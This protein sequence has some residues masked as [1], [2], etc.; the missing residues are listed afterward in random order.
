MVF[1]KF[2][3]LIFK[4]LLLQIN[5][6][7]RLEFFFFLDNIQSYLSYSLYVN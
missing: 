1:L 3:L 2:G 4:V 5:K 6:S 7:I